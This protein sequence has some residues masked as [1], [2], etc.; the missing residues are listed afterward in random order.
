LNI[1]SQEFD[2]EFND[3]KEENFKEDNVDNLEEL[4]NELLNLQE[5]IDSKSQMKPSSSLF[6]SF[7]E[8][9]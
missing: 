5:N 8:K 7:K 4:E 6:F 1:F 2:N 3:L 9:K